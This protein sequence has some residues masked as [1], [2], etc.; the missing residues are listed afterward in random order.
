MKTKQYFQ[1]IVGLQILQRQSPPRYPTF[2]FVFIQANFS[3]VHNANYHHINA[4]S[5]YFINH[6][7]QNVFTVWYQCLCHYS[8]LHAIVSKKL[9]YYHCNGIVKVMFFFNCLILNCWV[10]CK[11]EYC[12]VIVNCNVSYHIKN[13]VL[14]F[15]HLLHLCNT[16]INKRDD[17]PKERHYIAN[18]LKY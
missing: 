1:S 9:N 2:C 8:F 4:F 6:F 13:I 10:N 16:Q 11:K 17:F 18:I 7:H 5:S 12:I 3:S 14:T 15:V